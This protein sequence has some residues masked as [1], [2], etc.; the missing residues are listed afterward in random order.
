MKVQLATEGPIF[1]APY[2]PDKGGV[3]FLGM[4]QVNLDMMYNC[5]PSINNVTYF[6]RPFS[7]LCWIYWKFYHLSN[8]KGAGKVTEKQLRVWRE[9]VETLFTWGHQLEG[10]SGIP[11]TDSKP[12][13]AG[14]VPLDFAS[15][16]RS[17][18]NTSLMAAVQYGPATKTIEGLGFLEPR[19]GSFFHTVGHGVALAESLDAIIRRFDR[20]GLLRHIGPSRATEQDARRLF[21]AWSILEPSKAE[22]EAFRTAFFDRGAVGETS[23]L[24]RRSATLQLAMDVLERARNP[25]PVEMIRARMFRGRHTSKNSRFGDSKLTP[26]WLRWVVLQIRQA[27]RLAMEGLLSWF[28]IQLALHGERHTDRIVEKTLK[29]VKEHDQIF[30]FTKAAGR[31]LD[32]IKAKITDLEEALDR[33]ESESDLDPLG[34][35]DKIERAVRERSEE[36]VSYCLRTLF[37]CAALTHALKDQAAARPEMQR[38]SA[39]RVSLTFWTDTLGRWRDLDLGEFLRLLFETLILSQHFAVAARRFDGQTQRLR[40][41]IEEDGLEFLADKP[42]VPSVTSDRLATALSLLEECGLIG[43]DDDREAYFMK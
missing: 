12:P 40:I 10:I 15:W 23:P 2:R 35:M 27:Q 30:P 14:T 28:E 9:K 36:L 31:A 41:S 32:V 29:V 7:L 37:L 11:G 18:T 38:G 33:S 26:C 21:Q 19:G 34:L 4:R 1:V 6:L 3:D 22:R 24:G 43:W 20:T 39:D 42:L 16:R 13:R 5:L 8:Q 25:L 17:A